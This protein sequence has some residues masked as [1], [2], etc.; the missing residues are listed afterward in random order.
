[1]KILNVFSFLVMMLIVLACDDDGIDVNLGSFTAITD[2]LPY[3][4]LSPDSDPTYWELN[5]RRNHEVN[6]LVSSGT[7][8]E[9]AGD[10]EQCAADFELAA[11]PDGGFAG[12]CLPSHCYYFI[13]YQKNDETF[14][15]AFRSELKEFLGT[16]DSKADAIILAVS[17]G[18][19]FD[20]TRKQAGAVK[21][22]SSG[23]ELLMLKTKSMCSPVQINRVHLKINHNGSIHTVGEEVDYIKNECPVI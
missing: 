5:H 1:M 7:K 18:Y 2:P 19:R 23:Y 16:I 6:V 8:C 12:G 13:R 10:P 22:T 3:Q 9:G 17:E 21:E 14:V 20:I 11:M 15:V 4:D